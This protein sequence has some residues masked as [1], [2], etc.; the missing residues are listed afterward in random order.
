M[1]ELTRGDCIAPDWPAP[2]HVQALITTRAGGVSGGAY[3]TLNLGFATADDEWAVET[4][5]A[6]LAALLPQP[7]RWLKQV[8]GPRVVRADGLE[9]RP[10]ADASVAHEVGTVCA[11]LIA[12]CL[13]VLF[14]NRDGTFVAAAHAG[15]RGLAAGILDNT[16]TEV[17]RSGVAVNDLLAYIG[18]G[19]GPGAFEVGT[20]VYHAFVSD[21]P[22]AAGAFSLRGGG[23]WFGDLFVLARRVLTRCGIRQIFGGGVCTYSDPDRFY[24]YRRD[25]VTGRM[26]A[27][28]WR[29]K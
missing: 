14:T 3:A 28:I 2:P 18:P 22:G 16:I 11:I 4:N 13:P 25:K 15:W 29:D 12:D 20:D 23:K 5:R 17:R 26:A 7:P 24:S 27:L 21:D 9:Q 8:H 19:V 6:R 10:E 1:R